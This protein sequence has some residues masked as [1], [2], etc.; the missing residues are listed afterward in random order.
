MK[1]NKPGAGRLPKLK[2]PDM[3]A[4]IKES[5][6]TLR[7]IGKKHFLF[8]CPKNSDDGILVTISAEGHKLLS[9]FLKRNG[10]VEGQEATNQVNM[11]INNIEKGGQNGQ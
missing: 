5:L 2:G 4:Y 9:G 10:G 6:F 7:K 8:V 3:Q 11:F 1:N